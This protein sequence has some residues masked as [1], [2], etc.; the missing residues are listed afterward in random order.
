MNPEEFD[1]V[2]ERIRLFVHFF[3]PHVQNEW[4]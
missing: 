3:Y 2:E 1:A 4:K